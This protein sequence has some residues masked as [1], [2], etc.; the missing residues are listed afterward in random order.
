LSAQ[1]KVSQTTTS[2]LQPEN[3]FKGSAA[4]YFCFLQK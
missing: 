1:I 2:L 4:I 3:S